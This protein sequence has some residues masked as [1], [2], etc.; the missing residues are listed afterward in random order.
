MYLQN[1]V[2]YFEKS[3]MRTDI[4]Y[5]LP[6]TVTHRRTMK[7]NLIQEIHSPF[8]CWT[9]KAFN[10]LPYGFVV[11]PPPYF[12]IK[13][14]SF[15]GISVFIAVFKKKKRKAVITKEKRNRKTDPNTLSRSAA[16]S[17]WIKTNPKPS[18]ACSLMP[19]FA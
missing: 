13:E 12:H 17:V 19:A 8:F 18:C 16:A 11:P 1:T 3:W 7:T 2:F 5:D 14:D 10:W 4:V 9:N 6:K 15:Y